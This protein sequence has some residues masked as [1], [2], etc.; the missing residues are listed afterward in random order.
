MYLRF[1]C[2]FHKYLR[3]INICLSVRLIYCP[4][5]VSIPTTI[6][7]K[8]NS[9]A[10]NLK[11]SVIKEF[12]FSRKDGKYIYI[13]TENNG[14]Y[15][16]ERIFYFRK[17]CRHLF[18][19][20]AKVDWRIFFKFWK[21]LQMYK[22]RQLNSLKLIKIIYIR[23]GINIVTNQKVKKSL[24]RRLLIELKWKQMK[25]FYGRRKG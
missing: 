24:K 13:Y 9:F 3:L 8:I 11:I 21:V 17:S 25:W 1:F 12:V 14:K 19:S 15:F 10:S 20:K 6:V 2:I 23:I 7:P 22:Q 16:E 5:N 18:P 4:Y